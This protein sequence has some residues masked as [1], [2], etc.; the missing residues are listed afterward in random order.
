MKKI[1]LSLAIWSVSIFTLSAQQKFT[2]N[3]HLTALKEPM[4]VYLSYNDQGRHVRD[5]ALTNNGKF[6]FTGTVLAPVKGNLYLSTIQAPKSSAP[7]VGQVM[8][9]SDWASLMIDPGTIE[10]KGPALTKALIS[11]GAAQRDY[12][13]YTA[14]S[15]KAMD[16]VVKIWRSQLGTLP[17]DSA[18]SFKRLLYARSVVGK[19]VTKDF[20]LAHA[21][22]DFAFDLVA[23]NGIVIEQPK[24]FEAIFEVLSPRLKASATGKVLAERL[25]LAKKFSIG[26]PAID[27]SQVDNEGKMVSLSDFKGKYVL[28]DFWASWCG[29][30][31]M[32]YPFLHKAYDRFKSKNFEIVGVSL[33]DN[34]N[35][36]LNSI[37]ENNFDWILLCD[38]KGRKNEVAQAYGVAAIPQSFLI[39]PEGIIIAK[40][41]RGNEL[42]AKLDEVLGKLDD[43]LGK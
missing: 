16:S 36:W 23:Q 21:D 2:I 25:A 24:D 12:E 22:S 14:V 33:D 1:F 6:K 4:K 37:K 40:N 15:E 43:A 32:E 9:S 13:V 20:V 8:G 39:N 42:L 10:I 27:F 5:S 7:K 18:A 17:E 35:L 3:G 30:C 34:K 11:G 31:R 26:A 41:L 19:Q 29:P 38:L 28:I